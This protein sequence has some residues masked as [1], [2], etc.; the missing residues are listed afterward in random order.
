MA[1]TLLIVRHG[2][3]DWNK[4]ERFRGRT[5]LPLNDHGRCQVEAV[6]KRIGLEYR[7]TAIYSSR[8][9][10]AVQT[11]GAIAKVT[12]LPVETD[13]GLLDLDYGDFAGLTWPEAEAK[14]PEVYHN[15][16]NAPHIVRFP[17]GESLADV[18]ARASGLIS[19]LA[20]RYPATQVVLTTHVMVCRV[21]LCS[22]MG[23]HLGHIN[24]FEVYPASLSVVELANGTA[25]LMASNDT[26]H[27][28]AKGLL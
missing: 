9:Q 4:E 2:E 7:P 10:R 15:W 21:L 1:T 11:A 6:A 18:S 28:R 26:R 3:T 25:R 23:L 12:G 24:A 20:E 13:D 5:D 8:L 19:R 22:L 14:F 16:M 17:H 27:L